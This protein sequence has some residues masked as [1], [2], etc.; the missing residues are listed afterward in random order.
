MF[1]SLRVNQ[2]VGKIAILGVLFAA[3][4][5][6]FSVSR[7]QNTAPERTITIIDNGLYFQVKTEKNLVS[8]I[9]VDLDLSLNPEDRIYPSLNEEALWRIIIERATPITIL[10]DGKAKSLVTF[11]KTAGA[12]LEEAQ[13]TL[14]PDDEVNYAADTSLFSN[15]EIVVTRIKLGTVTKDVSIPFQTVNKKDDTLL[16]GKFKI[17]QEGKTGL[18]EQV[19]K[20][21][22]KNGEEA[23]RILEKETILQKP[24]DKIILEGTKI[25]LGEANYG[26]ASF[27]RYGDKLT[28]ASTRFPM[29]TPLRVTNTA[30]GQA[31]IVTVN[32]YG[33]FVL[34]RI[35]DLNIPAFEKIAPLGTG[36]ARV[37][38]EEI[39]D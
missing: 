21:I 11:A 32:D 2:A 13:I 39:I 34:G 30:N 16:W 19:Y 20:V 18:K 22:Y 8:E 26:I 37:K 6:S 1:E 27:Y 5:L 28:C 29:G 33:P 3:I 10:A 12:A 4:F 14:N 15:M 36:L 17:A 9:L 35:V 24:Q 23:K 25:V 7:A 38:V 31:V